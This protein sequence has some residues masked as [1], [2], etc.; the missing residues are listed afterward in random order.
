MYRSTVGISGALSY[1]L[2]SKEK[3]EQLLEH[4]V[5]PFET[6][7]IEDIRRF[8]LASHRP[9]PAASP[10]RRAVSASTPPPNKALQVSIP[11]PASHIPVETAVARNTCKHCGS[12]DLDILYGKYGYY[13][14][15]FACSGSS[16]ITASCPRCSK[17]T[18]LSKKGSEFT[19]NCEA[20][21]SSTHFH[22][23]PVRSQ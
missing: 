19:S 10:K 14:K 3:G 6:S 20:C 16:N 17:R 4:R 11:L 12:E 2:A 13:F 15:C 8:L 21:C 18:K 7:E 23:N 22:T 9:L 5:I 1:L